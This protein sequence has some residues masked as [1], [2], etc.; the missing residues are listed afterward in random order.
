MPEPGSREVDLTARLRRSLA[1]SYR[2][3]RELGRG[4]MAIVYLADD[5]KHRREV[6]LKVLRPELAA[7]LGRTRFLQEIETAARLNH[8]FIL[9]LYQSGEADGLLYYVMPYVE[10]ETLRQRLVREKQLPLD[11]A[12]GIVRQV[13]EAI[14]YAHSHGIVHRDLKPENILFTSGHAVVG[15]FGIARAIDVAAES[16]LTEPGLVLGTP[17]YMSPE[18]SA[19]QHVDHRSD[20]YALACI[21]YEMV[22]GAPPF[23]GP[24]PQAILARHAV[25]P[26]PAVRTLRPTVP[27]AMQEVI[28]RA[29]AKIPADRFA[30]A[31]QFAEALERAW[32]GGSAPSG[33]GRRAPA[34][35]LGVAAAVLVALVV[36][37]RDLIPRLWPSAAAT[38]ELSVAVLPFDN[39]AADPAQEYFVSGMTDALVGELGQIQDLR[40]TWAIRERYRDGTRAIREVANELDVDHVVKASVLRGGD[41]VQFQVRLIRARPAEELVWSGS[42]GGHVRQVLDLHHQAARAIA[43]RIGSKIAAAR[44]SEAGPRSVDPATYEAYL[45]GMYLINGSTPDDHRRGI[46]YLEEATR[47][48]PGSARAWAGL[49]MGYATLG[50][51]PVPPPDAWPKARAAAQRA[52]T[53]DPGLAEGHAALA[54]VKLYYEMDWA[55]AEAAFIRTNQLNPNLA[56]NRFHYAWYL[57]LVDRLDE[58]I[59]EHRKAQELDPLTP[60]HTAWLA[61]L[62]NYAGRYD[63][64]IA[65]AQKSL[66]MD[67]RLAISLFVIGAAYWGKGMPDSAI[68]YLRQ[69]SAKVAAWPPFLGAVLA[70]A[71]RGAEARKIRDEWAARPPSPYGAFGRILLHSALGEMDEAF[72]WA[73]YRPAHAWLPWLRNMPVPGLERFRADPRYRQFVERLNLPP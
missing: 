12:I 13:A 10:G 26:V 65:E 66:Q 11:E 58:A 16:R 67:D 39:L 40:V 21:A 20:I 24:T 47:R 60:L 42:Y 3:I 34:L 8:P 22:G 38:A 48:D 31:P 56:M 30:T 55:G 73:D 5:L 53:L 32:R 45:R 57:V 17:A 25:D 9:P 6:A 36:A 35:R 33:Y 15:D 50:H 63:D 18:Q 29:L 44:D 51:G 28:A 64:A 7:V 70:A 59:A 71:G 54:D 41:S 23:D 37:V 49:A 19:G 61:E 43:R 2:L 69:A 72:R 27:L 68:A 1:V 14:G 62:Y 52:V 46:A 4:G